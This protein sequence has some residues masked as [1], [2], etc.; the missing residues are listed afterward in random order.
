MTAHWGFPIG[1]GQGQCS[2]IALAFKNAYACSINASEI[3]TS[4]PLRSLDH[5]TLQNKLK[6]T[7]APDA[8]RLAQ[9]GVAEC[10]GTAFLLGASSARASGREAFGRLWCARAALPIRFR[11]ARS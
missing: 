8:V 5:L 11:P 3:F 1:P 10:L 6:E 4:L 7:A 2:E 9:R